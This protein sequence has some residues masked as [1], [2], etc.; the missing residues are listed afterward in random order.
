MIK[1]NLEILT[2]ISF[3]WSSIVKFIE[4]DTDSIKLKIKG[5]DMNWSFIPNFPA[6]QTIDLNDY[7]DF[8]KNVPIYIK[9]NLNKIPNLG[10]Q[11]KVDDKKKHLIRRTLESNMF[12]YDGIPLKIKNLNSGMFYRFSLDFFETFNL[13][14]DSGKNCEDY[15]TKTFSSYKDCDMDF[16]YNKMR[17]QYKLMPFWAAKTLDEVTNRM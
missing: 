7:F 2:E 5:E 12:D 3:D 14:S 10:V 17:N 13:K 1:I 9:F 11:L 16:V 15:P 6:C 8:N 4:V